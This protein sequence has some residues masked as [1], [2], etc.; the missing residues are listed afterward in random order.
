METSNLAEE[1][2]VARAKGS[3]LN[4]A[5]GNDGGMVE[6]P[7]IAKSEKI[8]KGAA[9]GGGDAFFIGGGGGSDSATASVSGGSKRKIS[10]ASPAARA[11]KILMTPSN[12]PACG[13]TRIAFGSAGGRTKAPANI[14]DDRTMRTPVRTPPESGASSFLYE[15]NNTLPALL[16]SADDSDHD[17]SSKAVGTSPTS[18][19]AVA[20][21]VGEHSLVGPAFS[22][23]RTPAAD[24]GGD[25][26]T[27]GVG[28]CPAD[29]AMRDVFCG[30]P[31]VMAKFSSAWRRSR[32]FSFV[33]GSRSLQWVEDGRTGR[34]GRCL[35]RR[36][37]ETLTSRL[38][39]APY[40]V[41]S[42]GESFIPL[43][44]RESEDV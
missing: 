38:A 42:A 28:V 17:P 30:G 6:H 34:G 15:A 43:S 40:T 19:P 25:S 12:A 22:A 37:W 8:F 24:L 13:D 44:R 7:S 39:V 16:G 1:T 10:E 26:A 20:A 27:R 3:G 31:S 11:A 14:A 4:G 36:S 21:T 18:P 5:L 41:P 23:C 9:S 2:L 32:C 29:G 33:L 35:Y